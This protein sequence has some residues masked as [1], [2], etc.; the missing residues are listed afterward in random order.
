MKDSRIALNNGV[1][2]DNKHFNMKDKLMTTKSN[3]NQIDQKNTGNNKKI[4]DRKTQRIPQIQQI[5]TIKSKEQKKV[6]KIIPRKAS[7]ENLNVQ[8]NPINN[9]QKRLNGVLN[10][11]NNSSNLINTHPNAK[12]NNYRTHSQENSNLLPPV[13]MNVITDYKKNLNVNKKTTKPN[14]AIN[15]K[16]SRNNT[17]I[18]HYNSSLYQSSNM[19]PESNHPNTRNPESNPPNTSYKN[20]GP[21]SL[22]I[23]YTPKPVKNIFKSKETPNRYPNQTHYPTQQLT[24]GIGNSVNK[25]FNFNDGVPTNYEEVRVINPYLRNNVQRIHFHNQL[26]NKVNS[27]NHNS[28]NYIENQLPDTMMNHNSPQ[29]NVENSLPEGRGSL[30]PNSSNDFNNY[31]NTPYFEKVKRIKDYSV[32]KKMR[33]NLQVENK[34]MHL[35]KRKTNIKRKSTL[36]KLEEAHLKGSNPSQIPVSNSNNPKS[37]SVSKEKIYANLPGNFSHISLQTGKQNDA[38]LSSE[39][40]HLNT[41]DNLNDLEPL[42]DEQ[43]LGNKIATSSTNYTIPNEISGKNNIEGHSHQ[44]SNSSQNR[45][46]EIIPKPVRINST[47]VNDEE[48]DADF[49]KYLRDEKM[50]D[51][52]QRYAPSR[53]NKFIAENFISS[54]KAKIFLF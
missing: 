18:N 22:K 28:L 14:S 5:I 48:R 52:A 7:S 42:N 21:T 41:P 19:N 43:Y 12:M 37:P 32:G 31:L 9:Y 38:K 1:E 11:V 27:A 51:D 8:N 35:S 44:V 33:S 23:D 53:I 2:M 15:S 17:Y 54:Y 36:S 40:K 45:F 47:N 6:K 30:T 39:E 49:D 34:N 24:S 29:V 25:K 4:L 26:E 16:I 20:N 50:Y 13:K 10:K 46:E 3:I